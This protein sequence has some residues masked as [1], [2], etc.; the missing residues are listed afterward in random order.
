MYISPETRARLEEADRR[1]GHLFKFLN[2]THRR[3][4][5]VRLEGVMAEP[6]FWNSQQAAKKI[7]EELNQNKAIV[8]PITAY[9]ARL[10]DA[11]TLAEL[12]SGEDSGVDAELAEL[13][14]E[15][16]KL[17]EAVDVLEISSFLSG[18]MD[19]S[20]A[21]VTIK[22]GAGGTEACDWADLLFRMYFRWAERRGFK[23]TV[24]DVQDGEG[25]GIS[26]AIVRVEGPNAYGYMKAERGVHRLV[27]ISPYDANARRHTSFASIDVVAE[28][29]DD[30][31][32]TI[33]E[34][35]VRKDTY[36]S[37]GKGGQHVNKTDSAVRLTHLATGIVVACQ[38]ERSQIQN[39]AVAM[40]IL[41]ARLYE[42]LM[43]DR[44]SEMERYYGEKGEVGWGNQIRSYVFQPYQMVKD[45]RTGVNTGNIQGVM[46]GDIDP[47]INGWLR[48]GG[49]RQRNKD[50]KIDD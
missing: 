12:I 14:I 38:R 40:Q 32:V 37:G 28:V 5:I 2:V 13:D 7:I 25:A 23:F 42:K 19:K 26:T 18:P 29:T 10:D 4:E 34:A 50:I 15:A 35:D 43:D 30:I 22:A 3:E 47:F 39:Y 1:A 48:A 44:R 36:R 8:G 45:L 6:G 24:E 41:K 21:I 11:K 46:D 49:P 31:D 20:N 9:M 33:T 27:R 16:V 17:V